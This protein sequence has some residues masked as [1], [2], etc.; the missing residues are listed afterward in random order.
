MHLTR[1]KQVDF[2]YV[3][4]E[5]QEMEC[6]QCE[7][8]IHQNAAKQPSMAIYWQRISLKYVKEWLYTVRGSNGKRRSQSLQL[9]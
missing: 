8:I 1:E 2:Y 7:F 9:D 6:V 4:G 5:R 3:E